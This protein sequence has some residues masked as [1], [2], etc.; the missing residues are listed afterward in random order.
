[1]TLLEIFVAISSLVIGL[2]PIF[3]I[4]KRFERNRPPLF[5]EAITMSLLAF[6][7]GTILF[8]GLFYSFGLFEG[9]LDKTS[10]LLEIVMFAGG[11]LSLVCASLYLLKWFLETVS[12]YLKKFQ[13]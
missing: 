6:M 4:Q 8:S 11:G 10:F 7:A 12:D 5:I 13:P 1:M 9:R 2:T 3:L